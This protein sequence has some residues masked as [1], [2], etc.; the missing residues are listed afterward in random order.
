MQVYKIQSEFQDT[1]KRLHELNLTGLTFPLNTN[2]IS[3]FENQNVEFAVNVYT[4]YDEKK[5]VVP[6]R[7]TPLRGRKYHVNL[8]LL[9]NDKDDSHYVLVKSESRL[10]YGRTKNNSKSH[11]CPYCLHPFD[12]KVL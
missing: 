7:I 6:L 9:T 11:V 4:W 2:Q 12:K 1:K 10:V 3:K 8:I 5:E